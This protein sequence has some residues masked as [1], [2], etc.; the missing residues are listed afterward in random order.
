MEIVTGRSTPSAP[1]SYEAGRVRAVRVTNDPQGDEGAV[2]WNTTSSD[3]VKR[4]ETV[5]ATEMQEARSSTRG[6]RDKRTQKT[7]EGGLKRS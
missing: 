7:V 3:C 4:R 2:G 5:G 1:T 6:R